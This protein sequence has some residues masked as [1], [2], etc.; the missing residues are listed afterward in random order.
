MIHSI[1]AHVAEK[2]DPGVDRN[3][4][5]STLAFKAERQAV[6]IEGYFQLQQ[7]VYKS[8]MQRTRDKDLLYH[9]L[10]H[11][12][13]RHRGVDQRIQGAVDVA[14]PE[15][16]CEHGAGHAVLGLGAALL[17]AKRLQSVDDRESK[18]A[19]YEAQS[20]KS[21]GFDRFDFVVQSAVVARPIVL[22]SGERAG[23]GDAGGDGLVVD[24]SR[25]TGQKILASEF[26]V[27]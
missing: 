18:P 9:C 13:K 2:P 3:T 8:F 27:R 6:E 5:S 15:K 7:K 4:A 17:A 21:N 20:D 12:S 24:Q 26:L 25:R 14:Q 11:G 16:K 23:D 22:G 10:V 19:A 1:P